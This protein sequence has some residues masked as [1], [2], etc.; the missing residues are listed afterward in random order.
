LKSGCSNSFTSATP[1]LPVQGVRQSCQ[2]AEIETGKRIQR[3]AQACEP[4]CSP[5][6]P[7]M[8]RTHGGSESAILRKMLEAAFF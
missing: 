6:A 3:R 7:I 1:G 2:Q 5:M 4:I 8:A